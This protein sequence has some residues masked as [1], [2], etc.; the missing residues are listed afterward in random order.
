MRLYSML[1]TLQSIFPQASKIRLKIITLSA[2]VIAIILTFAGAIFNEEAENAMATPP[3]NINS[4][5][6]AL[7]FIVITLSTVGFGDK[8]PRTPSGKVLTVMAVIVVVTYLPT[9]IS[10][11]VNLLNYPPSQ[12]GYTPGKKKREPFVIIVGSM[13]PNFSTL[14][15][16]N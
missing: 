4:F 15:S 12:L 11:L 5:P 16:G 3:P 13:S 6:D 9:Q 8:C 1:P 7:Y 14:S 2:G 10:Q